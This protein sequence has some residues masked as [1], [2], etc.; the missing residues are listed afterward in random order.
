MWH[1]RA[2]FDLKDCGALNTFEGVPYVL[3]DINTVASIFM[4]EDDAITNGTI[5]IK[6]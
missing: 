1:K 2:F 4:A 5:I 6:G 3:G